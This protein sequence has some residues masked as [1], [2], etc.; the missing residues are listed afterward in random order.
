MAKTHA[1]VTWYAGDN[2][3][4]QATLLDANGNPFNLNLTQI[5]WTLLNA[6]GQRVLDEDDV[7][8]SIA[9]PPTSGKCTVLVPAAKTLPLGTAQYTDVLRIVVMGKTSTPSVG[10]IYV[11]A[12]PWTAQES[13]TSR[14][15]PAL[16]AC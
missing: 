15:R 5:L 3:E 1:A 16:L 4:I 6:A 9:D 7:I 12:D 2:W 13:G 10:P 8:I 14:Q 11:I